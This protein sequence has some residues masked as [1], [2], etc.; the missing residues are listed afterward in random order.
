MGYGYI[1][2][3]F[4]FAN[5]FYVYRIGSG[6]IR[7][8]G[9]VSTWAIRNTLV[10]WLLKGIIL[11]DLMEIIWNYHNPSFARKP[12]KQLRGGIGVL[13]FN[14]SLHWKISVISPGNWKLIWVSLK[15]GNCTPIPLTALWTFLNIN[16][17]FFP[18]LTVNPP[19]SDASNYDFSSSLCH[20][21]ILYTL[22]TY[23]T[24]YYYYTIYFMPYIYKPT[25]LYTL[26]IVCY[27]SRSRPRRGRLDQFQDETQRTLGHQELGKPRS[28]VVGGLGGDVRNVH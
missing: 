3:I 21:T 5:F 20:H 27:R 8:Y 25:I 23:Y 11:P 24:I 16:M 13:F 12:I 18:V 2:V 7:K 4:H 10:D 26:S 15:I 28:S 22:Y 14:G 6:M 1:I 17:A 19:F 9:S